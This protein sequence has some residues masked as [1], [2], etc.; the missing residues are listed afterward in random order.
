MKELLAVRGGRG[1]FRYRVEGSLTTLTGAR[2]NDYIREHLGEEFT[3]K[4]FRTWGGTLL[5]AIALAEH[6]SAES[7][8]E[9]K[10]VVA[11][12]MRAVGERL[13]NTAAVARASYVSP[14]V[15]EQY[16]DGR[17]IDDFRPR[18]LRVVGARD[19]GL[20]LEERALLALLRSWRIRRARL[21]A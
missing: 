19:A 10:R 8:T 6:R 14:A 13:G 9:A 1:L 4:D 7:E 17:T 11:S 15:V 20:D 18:H 12:V 16:F 5:A 2:L 3:A 21:A